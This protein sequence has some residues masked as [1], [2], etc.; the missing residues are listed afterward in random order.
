MLAT[1]IP[2][3]I[4]LGVMI[5]IHE[6]GHFLFA[7]LFKVKVE[8]FSLGFGPR[9]I[10][11]KWGDTDYRLSAVP[12]GGY[13]KMK[14]ENL[15]ENIENTGDEFL[16]KPKWQRLFILLAGP[17]FNILTAIAIPMML[18]MYFFQVPAYKTEPPV[19]GSVAAASAAAQAGILP[20]DRILK[21]DGKQ[22][23]TWHEVELKVDINPERPLEVV[24]ERAGQQVATKLTP[25]ARYIGREKVGASG[26]LPQLKEEPVIVG[27]VLTGGPAESAGLRADDKI[28]SLN[29]EPVKNFE[30]LRE[31]MQN[32]DGQEVTLGIERGG[33]SIELKVKPR[34]DNDQI[35]RVGFSPKP[36]TVTPVPL[37]VSKKNFSEAFVYSINKNIEILVLTKEA[38]GQIFTGQRNAKDAL[39]GPIGIAA[40]SGQAYQQGGI[41]SLLNLIAVLSLNL[42]IFNL[43]PIPVLDGGHIFIILLE[44]LL[45][46]LGYKLSLVLK[47]RMMQFGLVVLLL[48]M[49]FV[50]ISDISKYLLQPA[51][52]PSAVRQSK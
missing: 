13:V 31:S 14:G 23:R 24:L 3:A 50:I 42:G 10:G 4:V 36:G 19:V 27:Q 47:E 49:G 35:V 38:L 2:F 22:T 52:P 44:A 28:V 15:D 37:K 48:L 40:I 18:A 5:F 26:L 41:W 46:L 16:A 34:R 25:K 6:L 7:K 29:G 21:I 11:F 43:L 8:I 20:G 39:A 1:L 17:L 33:N 45:G 12:L 9:L 51:G 32:F 30:W